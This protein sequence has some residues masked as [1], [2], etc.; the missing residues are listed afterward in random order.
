MRGPPWRLACRYT[1]LGC[2]VTIDLVLADD[3]P[4]VLNGLEALFQQETDFRVLARCPTGE[5]TLEAVRRYRP[6]ILLLDIRM[7]GMDG[8]EVL[9]RMAAQ[10]LPTRVILLTAGIDEA[11]VTAAIGFGVAGVLLKEMAPRLLVQCVRTV[12]AGG[13]WLEKQS[14]SRAIEKLIRR[15]AGAGEL[16]KLLTPRESEIVRMVAKGLQN[17]EIGATLFISEGTVKIHLHNIYEKLH[18]RTRLELTLRAQDRG[19]T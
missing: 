8:L 13:Q 19:L 11:Q 10:K 4:I 7:P 9:R 3:H 6:A 2:E 15:E 16:A 14:V 1:G 17:K 18:V 5:A 12:H